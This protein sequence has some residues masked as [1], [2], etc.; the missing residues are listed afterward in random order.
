MFLRNVTSYESHRCNIPQDDILHISV[1]SSG[2]ET[3][4]FRPIFGAPTTALQGAPFRFMTLV[5][6]IVVMILKSPQ[7]TEVAFSD[8]LTSV[9]A[10]AHHYQYQMFY[11]A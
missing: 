10:L 1:T 8:M 6:S 2:L 11:S 7:F 5:Q 9:T 3:A 4:T